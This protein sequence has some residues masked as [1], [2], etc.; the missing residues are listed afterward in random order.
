MTSRLFSSFLSK[1]KR[2]S[3]S[4][5][6]PTLAGSSN[7][8]SNSSRIKQTAGSPSHL[9]SLFFQNPQAAVMADDNE[10]M[11]IDEPSTSGGERKRFEVKKVR[12]HL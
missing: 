6:F 3:P 8:S 11:E 9:L 10:E 2:L 5:F 4:F 12:S 7:S 1:V